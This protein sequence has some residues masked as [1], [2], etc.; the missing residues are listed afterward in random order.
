MSQTQAPEST[1][2]LKS[3]S[4]P[5]RFKWV[6]DFELFDY[7]RELVEYGANNDVAKAAVKP[8]RQVGKTLTGGAIAA[9]RAISGH[10]VMILG[11]FEDTVK[12]M[13]E[14]ARN[15]LETAEQTLQEAGLGLGTTQRNKT[16][17]QFHHSG[18]L[19]ART[20]GTDGTQ[21]RG[22]NPDVVL[23]DEDAY[24]KDS[25][26]T[27]VIEP[28]FSTHDSYEYYLF[29]TPAGKSGYFYQKVEHDDSFYSPHWPS[30]ISPL[31]DQSFLDEKR[32]ELDSLTYAQEYQGEFV[33]ESDSYL[34]YDLVQPC[35]GEP[36]LEG[37]QWLGV[38]VARKGKDRTVYT[39][40][41]ESGS[42]E[43]VDSEETSTI[44]GVVGRIKSLLRERDF[45]AV[46]VDENAV[47]G[48][49]VDD[50]G[51][52]DVMN[53]VTFSTKTKHRMYQSLKTAFESQELTLPGNRSL[54]DELTSLRFEFTQN[55][56]LKVHHPDGGH[57]DFADSLALAHYGMSGTNQKTVTRREARVNMNKRRS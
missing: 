27:E 16:D 57:D 35:V 10:D 50:P 43:V 40:I 45:E 13:M 29:S 11:P 15:H 30:K 17:W 25:I 51:L 20:V 31:I 28:F 33:D 18:R 23:I 52:K 47:G 41:D 19:R 22:K 24:I 55:G 49:V 34:P 3:L 7:Q 21:I 26:H 9:E 8:G 4:R 44:P 12:E 5:E 56:Y 36:V 37:S 1:E 46:L 6:F 38:D 53:G 32:D 2:D 54:I 39:A 48:G 42:V 14:A